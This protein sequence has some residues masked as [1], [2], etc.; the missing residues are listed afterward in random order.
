MDAIRQKNSLVWSHC[1]KIT[2]HDGTVVT[3]CNYCESEWVLSGSTSIALLHLKSQHSEKFSSED[4]RN[5]WQ[6]P[7]RR[8]VF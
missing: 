2:Q 3:K 1:R 5:I 6:P 7:A 8:Y 4:L